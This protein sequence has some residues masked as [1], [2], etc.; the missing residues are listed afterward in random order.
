MQKEL[1]AENPTTIIRLLGIN[2]MGS[3]TGNAAACDGRDIPWLQDTITDQVWID[4]NV[5]YRD[6][7]I[8]DTRGA[9]AA[10]Y[11]LTE[12]DLADPANYAEL[13]ALLKQIAGE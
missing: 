10:V 13:K 3:E 5:T 7:V 11:N 6:V 1:L 12:H 2:S 8:L 9:V 4:W